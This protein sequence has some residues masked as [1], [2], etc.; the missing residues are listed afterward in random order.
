MTTTTLGLQDP[1]APDSEYLLDVLLEHSI[2]A[3]RGGAAF[4]WAT[5]RGISLLLGDS[6]FEE[7]LQAGDFQLIIGVDEITTPSALEALAKAESTFPGL[8]VRAF[9]SADG[10]GLFHP[11][12]AW[13]LRERSGSLIVG[14]GNL[15]GGGLWDNREA[16]SCSEMDA[17]TM[18]HIQ[19]QWAA[20][21]TANTKRLYQVT[22]DQVLQKAEANRRSGRRRS[23][24]KTTAPQAASAPTSTSD[25]ARM[26]LVAEIP[27]SG[28]RWKQ[29]NFDKDN[30]EQFFGA[31]V[32]TQR[33]ML[34]QSLKPGGNLGHVESRPSV[35]V[36]SRNWRFEL[37]AASGLAYPA[38]GRPI[39]VFLRLKPRTFLYL[40]SM[41]GD[42]MH[43]EL[44]N[45]LAAE[46]SGGAIRR[47]REDV[48]AAQSLEAVQRLTMA[49]DL[50]F[51]DEVPD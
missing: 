40:L 32:G 15:T 22:D 10:E 14:S 7:Y 38:D 13:F 42:T 24:V 48:S 18:A 29:A 17:E 4:A 25:S 20:W 31:R 5:N 36:A 23:A 27:A 50:A 37:D 12:M 19:Q 8:D 16:F 44:R 46:A 30:Y 34:F 1:A 35:E 2:D 51:A 49:S 39:G 26:I 28:D 33:R 43:D 41:P 47:V 3:V 11:K 21:R 9:M 45:H 6:V